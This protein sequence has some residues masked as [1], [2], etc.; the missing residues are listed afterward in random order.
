MVGPVA[1]APDEV[2]RADLGNVL[3]AHCRQH[4][5]KI[6]VLAE[7]AKVGIEDDVV[8]VSLPTL[9]VE[10]GYDSPNSV[11]FGGVRGGS[12]A[13]LGCGVPGERRLLRH[14][15]LL[16]AFVRDALMLDVAQVPLREDGRG[17]PEQM[18]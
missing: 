1:D 14:R 7:L 2:E 6:R 12:D 17:V 11:S 4:A 15:Y 18:E 8:T 9:L 13:E 16:G 3:L 5:L 10:A